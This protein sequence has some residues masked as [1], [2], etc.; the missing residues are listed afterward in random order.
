MEILSLV[1]VCSHLHLHTQDDG[2]NDHI[3]LTLPL[4]PSPSPT[5]QCHHILGDMST[6]HLPSNL[7]HLKNLG[8]TPPLISP[9]VSDCAHSGT[10]SAEVHVFHLCGLVLGLIIYF[11][12]KLRLTVYTLLASTALNLPHYY[13]QWRISRWPFGVPHLH[14]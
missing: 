8:K 1:F 7:Y 9:L 14:I 10:R 2:S 11:C 3:T 6:H 4:P 13:H 5:S 12:A